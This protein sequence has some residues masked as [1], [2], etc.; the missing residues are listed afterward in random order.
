MIVRDEGETWQ[1]VSQ[2]DHGDVC[3]AIIE[4]WGNDTFARPVDRR[5][6][7]TAAR[8]HDDGW[9]IW[10]R[11]PDVDRRAGD[12]RPLNVFDI[13][14]EI[15]LAFF[16]AMIVAV[17][18]EDAYAGVLA[19]MHA[20]G[21]YSQRHGTDPSMK[22]TLE[23]MRRDQVTAFLDSLR[24]EHDARAEELAIPDAQR[25]VDYKLLQVAD[26]LC[27]Y[28]CLNDLIDGT[29]AWLA[30]APKGYDRE[31]A[32]LTIRPAGPWTI[33]IEPYPFATPETIFTLP[34]RVFP[35]RS[36]E[37]RSQF[38]DAYAAAEVHHQPITVRSETPA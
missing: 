35:K 21:L 16:R 24:R 15:H 28:F 6:L 26:R 3:A 8:R 37:S 20:V 31:D 30:P 38:A 34:R 23:D 1:V 29:D 14:I 27:L 25:W 22:M 4:A 7:A 36:W 11:T 18:D 2:P 10:E 12:G 33:T 9:A 17:S 19:S 5:A 32:E 13:D